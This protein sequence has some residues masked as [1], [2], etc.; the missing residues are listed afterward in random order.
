MAEQTDIQEYPEK[1]KI[2]DDAL[3][4]HPCDFCADGNPDKDIDAAEDG[5]WELESVS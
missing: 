5:T 2:Q 4:A 1:R 3:V